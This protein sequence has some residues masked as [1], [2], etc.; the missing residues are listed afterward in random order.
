[1]N[2]GR[3]ERCCLRIT[4]ERFGGGVREQDLPQISDLHDTLSDTHHQKEQ[5]LRTSRLA[6]TEIQVKY[7]KGIYA[8]RQEKKS[9]SSRYRDITSL[10][11]PHDIRSALRQVSALLV[12]D[13]LQRA[14]DPIYHL[15]AAPARHRHWEDHERGRMTR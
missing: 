3:G 13:S 2:I 6:D 8:A 10:S 1:M 15:S 5:R 9:I 4:G 14:H 11:E 7:A 12:R